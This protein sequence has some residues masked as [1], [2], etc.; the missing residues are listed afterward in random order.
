[1]FK[2]LIVSSLVL[3]SQFSMAAGEGHAGHQGLSVPTPLNDMRQLVGNWKGQT[4]VD[5]KMTP[6]SAN[7]RQ[8]SEGNALVETLLID[9]VEMMS[10]YHSDGE[11]VAVTHYCAVGNRPHLNL[12]DSADNEYTFKMLDT[13]GLNSK[14][15]T[16]MRQFV[17]SIENENQYT[18]QVT[19]SDGTNEKVVTVDMRRV[20]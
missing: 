7:Y 16:A 14:D 2:V 3:F 1:M 9:G 17:L 5:G 15:E 13:A 12:I 19:L 20:D 18:M 4:E 8:T 10:V 6:F 11:S